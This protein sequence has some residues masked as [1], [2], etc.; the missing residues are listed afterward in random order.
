MNSSFAALLSFFLSA[1]LSPF[2]L[3]DP[4]SSAATVYSRG[5]SRAGKANFVVGGRT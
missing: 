5:A 4:F 3:V 1:S 2:L